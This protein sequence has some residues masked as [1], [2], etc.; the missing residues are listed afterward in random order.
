MDSEEQKLKNEASVYFTAQ[1]LFFDPKQLTVK[2]KLNLLLSCI[3]FGYLA[4]AKSMAYELFGNKYFYC[5]MLISVVMTKKN[6]PELLERVLDF[7]KTKIEVPSDR[8]ADYLN[9]QL[10]NSEVPL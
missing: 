3:A 8:L 10:P 5:R 9:Q 6:A 2:T 1:S 4:I 7:L